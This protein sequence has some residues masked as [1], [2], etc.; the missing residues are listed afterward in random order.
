MDLFVSRREFAEVR[1]GAEPHHLRLLCIE[2]EAFRRTPVAELSSPW[3]FRSLELSHPWNSLLRSEC[4][5]NFRSVEL[6]QCSGLRGH[7]LVLFRLN[8]PVNRHMNT[9]SAAPT[10]S[11]RGCMPSS[12]CPDIPGH[13]RNA[14]AGADGDGV[15]RPV[16]T[17]GTKSAWW[18]SSAAS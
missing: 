16:C 3:N 5:K 14:S 4:S 10:S 15:Q 11:C 6:S 7:A 13:G 9:S 17:G 12:T 18:N 2:L 1:R 8:A